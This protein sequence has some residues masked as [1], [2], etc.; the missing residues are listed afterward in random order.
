M[1]TLK[2]L[3]LKKEVITNLNESEMNRVKG[4]SISGGVLCT[5]T[6]VA[7]DVCSKPCNSRN[8]PQPTPQ[9][10][11]IPYSVFPD[12][13]SIENSCLCQAVFLAK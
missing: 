12:C 11:P 1:K 2:K 8:C 3:T 13:C 5:K 7:G 6:T 4:G 9:P 10:T